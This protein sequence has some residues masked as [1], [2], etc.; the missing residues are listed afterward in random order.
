MKHITDE[1]GNPFGVHAPCAQAVYGYG[2]ANADSHVVGDHPRAHGGIEKG[3][4]FTGTTA[5]EQLQSVLHETGFTAKP[6]SDVAALENC[7]SPTRTCGSRTSGETARTRHRRLPV[8]P[9]SNGSSTLSSGP[10]TPTSAC[11]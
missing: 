10:L 11:P 5:G 2:D 9:T 4:P 7:F 6:Y 3:I 8:T 1:T